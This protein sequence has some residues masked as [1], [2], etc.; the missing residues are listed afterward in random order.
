MLFNN[1]FETCSRNWFRHLFSGLHCII[2]N[3]SDLFSEELSLI[4]DCL[5]D[6]PHNSFAE[7]NLFACL[8]VIFD[9]QVVRSDHD[10]Y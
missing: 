4:K 2:T 8:M 6:I 7:T 9:G 10:S 1:R 5:T 3:T